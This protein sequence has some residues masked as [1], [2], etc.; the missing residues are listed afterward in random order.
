MRLLGAD[1]P[2]VLLTGLAVILGLWAWVESAR[3]ARSRRR[4]ADWLAKHRAEA[5][6]ALPWASRRLMPQAGIAALKRQGE[7]EDAAFEALEAEALRNGRRTRLLMLL[8][9]ASLALTLAGMTFL[10]WSAG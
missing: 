4:M 8:A 10:G 5:W 2:V 6:A 9:A 1:L 7:T 3:Q